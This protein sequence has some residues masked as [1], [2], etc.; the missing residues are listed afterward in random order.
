MSTDIDMMDQSILVT[1]RGMLGPSED[2]QYFDTDFIPHINSTL[3]RLKTLGIG[4]EDRFYITGE[5]ETWAD[6]FGDA[7]IID[8]VISYM[9]LKIKMQFD[10]PSSSIAAEAFNNQIKEYEWVM[11]VDAES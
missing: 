5:S 3:N 1:M 4:P 10:P 8:M 9:F 6:L 7:K 2:Y 11:N